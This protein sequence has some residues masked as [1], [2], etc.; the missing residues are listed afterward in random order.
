MSR[1]KHKRALTHFAQLLKQMEDNGAFSPATLDRLKDFADGPAMYV[2]DGKT[3]RRVRDVLEWAQCYGSKER[4][5]A[6]DRVG[7]V[8]VSTIFLGIDSPLLGPPLL[9]E[10]MVFGGKHDRAQSRYETYDEALAGHQWWLAKVTKSE[11]N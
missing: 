7:G 8:T 4:Q 5:L 3:P 2:L 11:G 6:V 9:F 1:P 10:T